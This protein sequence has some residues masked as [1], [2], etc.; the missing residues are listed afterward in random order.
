MSLALRNFT[1]ATYFHNSAK[2]CKHLILRL[3]YSVLNV[4]INVSQYKLRRPRLLNVSYLCFVP[5]RI[6]FITPS[7]SAASAS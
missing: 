2:E 4:G 3:F 7:R 5:D 6:Q 1:S